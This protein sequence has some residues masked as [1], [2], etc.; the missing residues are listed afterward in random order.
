[1]RRIQF[2][3]IHD[4]EWLPAPIRDGVT[5]SLQFGINLL[6][7]YRPVVP[8]LRRGL[9][10]MALPANGGHSVVDLCSGGGGPWLKL[11][12]DLEPAG[13]NGNGSALQI[14]LTDKYPNLA[15]FEKVKKA[16]DGR[17]CFHSGSVDAR[18]VPFELRGFR[19]MFTSFHHFPVEDARA[20]LQNAVDAGEGI[21]VFEVT[22]RAPKTVI[23]VSAWVFLL[24]LSAFCI[25]PFRWS[26]MF[27]TYV[28]PAIP[29]VLLFD[30]VVSC[31]R[32]YGPDELRE[33]VAE[34][35]GAEYQW[36]IGELSDGKAPLTYLI[37]H[38]R[39]CMNAR[40]DA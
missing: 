24:F 5:S 16:S 3:E 26:R 6:N 15:A 18:Q 32:T 21:G 1:M 7:T 20:I 34:L 17:I 37:G 8:L 14:S 31:L 40:A 13:S 11:R 36:E 12:R 23:V 9:D 29:V 19:T 38:P 33:L 4:Q 27:W 39:N 25:R 30:G 28:V 22:R 35:V 10:A 2:I